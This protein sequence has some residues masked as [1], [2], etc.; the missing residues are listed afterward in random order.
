MTFIWQ[1]V[2]GTALLTACTLFH[3]LI[4]ALA[5][6]AFPRL[7]R[8]LRH[9]R[10]TLRKVAVLS[11]GVFVIVSGHTVQIWSWALV[12]YV[13]AAFDSFQASFYFAT[14]TYTTL[15]Y[16]D[17]LLAPDLRIFGTFAS[18]TGLLTF[19]VSSALLIGLVSHLLPRI[20]RHTGPSH[21]D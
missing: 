19:G 5:F 15:G 14:A 7:S 1:L 13:L 8:A 17:L 6:P 4:V 12:F 2:L 20:G 11:F 9:S 10:T 3:V 16:G 21:D 18:V